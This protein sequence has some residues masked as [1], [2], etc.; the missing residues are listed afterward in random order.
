[1]GDLLL[2]NLDVLNIRNVQSGIRFCKRGERDRDCDAQYSNELKYGFH[3]LDLGTET[4]ARPGSFGKEFVKEADFP[5]FQF[6]LLLNW[7]QG[8][9][10][11][12]FRLWRNK[13][14]RGSYPVIVNDLR[15]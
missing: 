6:S 4:W 9:L 8:I 1:M 2:V 11:F 7:G 13:E 12:V 5:A 15:D 3:C 14:L 10:C